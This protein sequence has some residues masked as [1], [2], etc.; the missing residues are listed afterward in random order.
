MSAVHVPP[1]GSQDAAAYLRGMGVRE[2]FEET[3]G[4]DIIDRWKTN[5]VFYRKKLEYSGVRAEDAVTV[6]DLERCLDL[7]KHAGFARTF[8][9]APAATTS[10]HEVIGSLSELAD[11]L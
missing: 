10:S 11:C 7:A 4:T 6:D 8:L 3:Y 5:V 1:R 2:L 9:I